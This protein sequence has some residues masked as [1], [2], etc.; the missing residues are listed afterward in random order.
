MPTENELNLPLEGTEIKALLELRQA[1]RKKWPQ[2]KLRV[3]GSKAT[4]TADEESDLDLLIE[5]P[6]PV[7]QKIRREIIHQVFDLNLAHASNI[8]VLIVSQEEWEQGTL[9]L[10]PIHQE[11]EEVGISL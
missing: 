9:S 4:Q 10:L 1:V 3:F 8:S 5:L 2:A 11:V 6:V 7:D